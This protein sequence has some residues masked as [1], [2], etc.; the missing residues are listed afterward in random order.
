MNYEIL[1]NST[2]ININKQKEYL[3]KLIDENFSDEKNRIK[4]DLLDNNHSEL[5]N[6][7]NTE[8]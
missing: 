4:I 2:S 1:D 5:L 7:L 3:E 8:N 6:K